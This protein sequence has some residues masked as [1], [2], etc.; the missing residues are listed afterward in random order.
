MKR[1]PD[2]LKAQLVRGRMCALRI[3]AANIQT[4]IYRQN[5]WGDK[6]RTE[7][8]AECTQ[9]PRHT[10]KDM[11]TETRARKHTFDTKGTP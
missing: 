3:Y 9:D 4:W 8:A 1:S 6:E 5:I 7:W 2:L 11:G 10:H